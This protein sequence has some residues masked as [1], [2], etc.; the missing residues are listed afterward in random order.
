MSAEEFERLFPNLRSRGYSVS[1][2]P[3]PRYNC[4]SWALNHTSVC[5]D[6]FPSPGCYWPRDIP[7][8]T[9][10]DSYEFLFRKEGYSR[11]GDA[12]P[13]QGFEKIALFAQGNSFMHVARLTP[14]GSWTSKIGGLED[15]EHRSL[16]AL[17]PSDYGTVAIVMRQP[18]SLR[19]DSR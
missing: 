19:P 4:A 2:A 16:D 3:D 11:C 7:R 17:Q 10:V 6:P 18:L 15:I 8:D 5:Y 9:S 14:S 12:E 13:E 1:S